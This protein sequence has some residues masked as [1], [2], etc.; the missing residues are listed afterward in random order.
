MIKSSRAF[1]ANERVAEYRKSVAVVQENLLLFKG[2]LGPTIKERPGIESVGA[3]SARAAGVI[4]DALGKFRCPPGTTNANQFTDRSMSNCLI[5][6]AEA[7]AKDA[8]SLA[9][10]MIDGAKV[11]FKNRNVRNGAKAAAVVALQTLDYLQVDGSGA[12]TDSTL[13]GLMLFRT[14]GS[15]L[16]DFATDSL[17]KRGKISDKRKEQ[18]DKIASKLK[19]DGI[20][21]ARNFVAVSLKRR[22]DKKEKKKAKIEDDKLVAELRS[23]DVGKP[24]SDKPD[25]DT[26]KKAP[27]KAKTVEEGIQRILAGEDVEMED[28]QG[29]HTLVKKL[30][31]M[32]QSAKESGGKK[33]EFDLCRISV[34]NTNLF[35]AGNKG[36]DRAEMPQAKGNV[37][38]GSEAEKVLAIQ[39]KARVDAGLDPTEEVDG[40]ESFLKYLES[41]GIVNLE[42]KRVRSD[43]LKATQS[44]MRGEQVGG[45]M[46]SEKDFS[47]EPIFVSRDGYVVDGHHRWAATVG[48]DLENGILGD[49]HQMNVIVLDAPISQILRHANKWT[50][51]FGIKRKTVSK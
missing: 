48:K 2:F 45:M 33:V 30:G 38:E 37:V 46:N 51:E 21:D 20:A 14:G 5:P 10:K 24:D 26:P 42:P 31:E 22:K 15:E 16:L 25:I 32:A 11:I 9:G 47:A 44:N 40:T 41:Q 27:T 28:I 1:D 18:L 35:C 4:V 34:P 8:A 43:K 23:M 7:I 17:H 39:N 13:M 6:S 12:L 50:D 49:E 29:A 36:I 19:A 3:R